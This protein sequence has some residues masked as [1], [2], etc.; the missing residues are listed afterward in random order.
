[1]GKRGLKLFIYVKLVKLKYHCPMAA[2]LN[3]A[4]TPCTPMAYGV[5]RE[6]A[7]NKCKIKIL[8]PIAP[9]FF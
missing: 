3:G 6:W 2:T 4:P 5:E 7:W 1:M 9:N 8:K